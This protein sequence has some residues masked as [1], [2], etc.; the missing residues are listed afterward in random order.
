MF[1]NVRFLGFTGEWPGSEA[2]LSESLAAAGFTPCGP[3]T[4]KTSGFEP[5]A[6]DGAGLLCRRVGGADLIQLRIQSRVLPTAAI[7]EALDERIEEYRDRMG[8]P[9]GRREKRRL[10]AETRD[11]LMTKALLRSERTRACFLGADSVLA[12][13]AA[14]PNRIDL[15]LDMLRPGLGKFETRALEYHRPV[16]T[17]LERIFLGDSVPDIRLGRECRMQDPSD[18]RATVR[19]TDMDLADASIRRHVRDG[20]RLTHLGI[21]YDGIMSAV[22]DENGGLGKLRLLG[23]DADEVAA[24]EDMLTRFD[25]EFVLL[26]GTLRRFLATLQQALGSA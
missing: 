11:E 26:T 23:M 13:D 22:L 20:M 2:E 24:E 10:K 19:W 6:E 16:G 7:N 5:P 15:L 3:L 18:S 17:L 8:E 4:E 14:S 25:A 21:E 1:R 12:T 9:P